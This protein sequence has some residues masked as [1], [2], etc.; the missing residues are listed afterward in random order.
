MYSLDDGAWVNTSVTKAN[1]KSFQNQS[2]ATL[3]LCCN[4]NLRYQAIV[5]IGK[6]RSLTMKESKTS[7][8]RIQIKLM[9]YLDGFCHKVLNYI[10]IC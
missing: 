9:L 3:K 8:V 5:A 4:A 2:Q 10:T 7:L 1:T 6:P